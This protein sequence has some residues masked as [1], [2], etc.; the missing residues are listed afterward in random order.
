M[1]ETNTYCIFIISRLIIFLIHSII[2]QLLN[3]AL[4]DTPMYILVLLVPFL[5]CS[6][7]HLVIRIPFAVRTPWYCPR[8]PTHLYSP[9]LK[10]CYIVK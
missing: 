3:L 1:K 2:F 9:M 4:A 10:K 7:R 6:R 8:Y 5:L